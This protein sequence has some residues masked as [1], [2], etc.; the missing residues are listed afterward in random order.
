MAE[1]CAPAKLEVQTVLDTPGRTFTRKRRMP[2]ERRQCNRSTGRPT[3]RSRRATTQAATV[4]TDSAAQAPTRRL[5]R[6]NDTD[7][8]PHDQAAQ[9]EAPTR[10]SQR[11]N[12][13]SSRNHAQHVVTEEALQASLGRLLQQ[14]RE[15]R[16]A[17][18]VNPPH[19][20]V[21]VTSPPPVATQAFFQPTL[22]TQ[23]GM[24]TYN[25]NNNTT[26]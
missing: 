19:P 7:P 8:R 17:E 24:L 13:A 16:R 26:R 11:S 18:M 10:R 25:I 15:E 20:P 6:P 14:I 12:A 9:G 2:K 21:P 3:R 1:Q 5:R 22:G 4:A 23:Q